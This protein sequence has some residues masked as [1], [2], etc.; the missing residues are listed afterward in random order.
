MASV[1]LLLD[2]RV[3]AL[4]SIEVNEDAKMIIAT[5][6]TASREALCP[7]CL[8][9]AQRVHSNY[10]GILADLPCSGQRVRWFVL[11]RRFWY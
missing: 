2:P 4:V 5:A 1:L 9:P 10:I 3:L 6:G 7:V 11:V 8:Q